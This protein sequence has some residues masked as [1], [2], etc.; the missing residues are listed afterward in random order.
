MEVTPLRFFYPRNKEDI[1]DI[2]Q[3]AEGEGLRVRAVGS[4]HSYSEAAK[5]EDYLLSMKRLKGAWKTPTDELKEENFTKNLVTAEAGIILKKLNKKLNAMDLALP[6][7]GVIDFQTISGA[8]LTGTHGTGIDKPAIPDMVRAIRLVGTGG[9][10]YQI[11]PSNGITDPDKY[12]ASNP[13]K[14]I[15]DDDHFY[16]TVLSFGGMGIIYELILEVAPQF[17]IKEKRYLKPWT[18]LKAELEDGSFME[19]VKSIDFVA[20]RVNPYKVKKDH[21][22]AIVEQRIVPKAE[23]PSGLSAH[24][25]NIISS[26][27][28][29]LEFLI[30]STIRKMNKLRKAKKIKNNINLALWATKDLKY[31]AKSY[32][33]LLQS[34]L[35]VARYGISS[36][37]AFE[38]D[39][40]KIIEVLE[41]IFEKAKENAEQ[42]ELYQSSH[43]PVR[44]VQP[45]R[46]YLSSA[47]QRKTVYIDVPLLYGT[48]GDVEILEGFQE[49]MTGE[50]LGGIPHWGKHNRRLYFKKGFVQQKFPKA[51]NWI[52]IRR[53]MDPKGAFL[54]DFIRQLGLE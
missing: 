31:F 18:E 19:K 12:R 39:A 9:Q 28:G 54:N 20:F 42:G 25:R 32:K 33:A 16:S 21:R 44:F 49:M 17:W 10:L 35:S 14:L 52:D 1:V 4:G 11:E 5:G 29:N 46:A 48:V 40:Q 51:Q 43:I 34:G 38:A 15:Q 23:E 3:D 6:N 37:F 24:F 26:I 7:M 53:K 36:E 22:C 30:E 13:V 27:L 50:Q 41:S 47:Y 45:S 2:V 8:L